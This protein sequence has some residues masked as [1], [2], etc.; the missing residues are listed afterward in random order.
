MILVIDNYDSF[1][2]NLARYFKRLGV[3]TQVVRNDAITLEEIADLRPQAVVLSPGPGTPVQAG[4]CVDIVRQFVADLPILGICL[5]HQAIAAALGGK[6]IRAVHPM[7]GRVSEVNHDGSPIF[8][9]VPSPFQAG[10]YHSLVVDKGSV[11]AEFSVTAT[12]EDGTIMAIEHEKYPVLGI[13]FH[14]ESVL[15]E[16]GF[17]ILANFLRLIDIESSTSA[18][19]L[20]KRE[21][22]QPA[23]LPHQLPQQPVTF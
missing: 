14:P 21:L 9:E 22:P 7:H 11:P 5:G 19:D 6:V 1:V 13:Q 2:H 20:M 23:N 8:A 4:I 10:R 12:C 18:D 17:T 15:T 3:S 16:H